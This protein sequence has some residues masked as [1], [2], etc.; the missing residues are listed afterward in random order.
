MGGKLRCRT[1]RK[2]GSSDQKED[3][4]AVGTKKGRPRDQGWGGFCVTQPWPGVGER[5]NGKRHEG[6]KCGFGGV[7]PVQIG[8]EDKK[9][10]WGLL[11]LLDQSPFPASKCGRPP[12]HPT[13]LRASCPTIPCIPQTYAKAFH[14]SEE[15]MNSPLSD[16]R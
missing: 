13:Q 15:K 7:F 6:L 3:R 8:Q 4:D 14:S 11:P 5:S 12:P 10:L 2:R 1:E 16:L 9:R